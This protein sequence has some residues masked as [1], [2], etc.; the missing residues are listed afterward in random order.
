MERR[1]LLEASAQ[2]QGHSSPV[3]VTVRPAQPSRRSRILTT[4][5]QVGSRLSLSLDPESQQK[6]SSR[7]ERAQ[8]QCEDYLPPVS[9]HGF[10]VDPLGA[11]IESDHRAI[12]S[13]LRLK[14]T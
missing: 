7:G 13:V 2:L 3:P 11:I 6:P 5:K 12:R 9:P 8:N 4:S 14:G 10:V 1:R